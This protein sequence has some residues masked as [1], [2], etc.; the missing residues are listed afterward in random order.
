M[1]PKAI[2]REKRLAIQ[3]FVNEHEQCRVILGEVWRAHTVYVVGYDHATS[4]R[5]LVGRPRT[6]EAA[7]EL[8]SRVQTFVSV[9][10]QIKART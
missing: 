3:R 4:Q 8:L 5:L 2:P 7:R 9:L 10:N 6:P 1:K